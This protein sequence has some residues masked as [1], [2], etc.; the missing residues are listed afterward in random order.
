MIS[1]IT[2]LTHTN[3]VHLK[4]TKFITVRYKADDDSLP[5]ID[6][7]A[8]KA[9]IEEQCAAIKSAFQEVEVVFEYDE[10]WGFLTPVSLNGKSIDV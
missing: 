1:V 2:L 6:S 9:I 10:D 4:L 5:L 8:S 3:G 7:C